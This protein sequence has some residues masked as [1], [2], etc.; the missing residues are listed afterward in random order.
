[1]LAG[2][3]I[4]AVPGVLKAFFNV[5]EVISCIMMNYIS[6]YYVLQF[7]RQNF[8]DSTNN[9]SLSV[10]VHGSSAVLPSA[11]L[12]KIFRVK[13]GEVWRDGVLEEIWRNS[14]VD[15]GIIIAVCIAIFLYILLEKTT[16]GFELKAC[17]LNRDAAKY[18]GINEKRSIIFSML[19]AG[20]AAGIGGALLHLTG[21]GVGEG[22][23]IEVVERLAPEGF[24]GIP[25]A[26][27]AMSNPLAIVF[28]AFFIAYLQI[29]GSSMVGF[30]PQ[31]V[32][33]IIAIIIYFSALALVF[34]NLVKAVFVKLSRAKNKKEGGN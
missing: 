27:L 7:T 16:F 11:G 19:I 30:A 13:V 12:D 25:V 9:H 29:G 23:R 28:T 15:S 8:Y 14:A 1:M 31:I 34:R 20:A 32:E 4:G 2:A 22:I 3:L 5:N 26:L 18:A 21:T 17:G 33:I 6:M 24:A 10:V